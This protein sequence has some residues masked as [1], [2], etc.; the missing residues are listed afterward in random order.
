MS[1]LQ[2]LVMLIIQL[3]FFWLP[4]LILSGIWYRQRAFA[5]FRLHAEGMEHQLSNT[6]TKKIAATAE[7]IAIAGLGLLIL[8]PTATNEN[9][10]GLMLKLS[11]QS[12]SVGIYSIAAFVL[13][14]TG[15][16][17]S[18]WIALRGR[19]K[20]AIWFMSGCLV[21]YGVAQNGFP[22]PGGDIVHQLRSSQLAVT[23]I[24]PIIRFDL[25]NCNFSGVDLWV[26][27]VHLGKTPVEIPMS[28]YFRSVPDWSEFAVDHFQ[29]MER[30]GAIAESDQE[31]YYRGEYV[32][33][34]IPSLERL[35]QMGSSSVKY[36][37]IPE[38]E[39]QLQKREKQA[40]ESEK[41]ASH[42][43]FI[44][45][46]YD[47]QPGTSDSLT[48]GWGGHR[49]LL[50]PSLRFRFPHREAEI[51]HLLDRARLT[52]YE[53]DADWIEAME[54]FGHDGW[55]AVRKAMA[56]EPEM[57]MVFDTWAAEKYQINVMRSSLGA[58]EKL[59]EIMQEADKQQFYITA[60]PAGR[61][62]E[63]LIPRIHF[64]ELLGMADDFL[65]K[66]GSVHWGQAN[67]L[68]GQPVYW[69]QE[70]ATRFRLPSP[71]R[72]SGYGLNWNRGEK[73][74]PS[75]L[76]L[77][78]ALWLANQQMQKR[79]SAEDPWNPIYDEIAP[80]LIRLSHLS[81]SSLL[82]MIIPLGGA[83]LEK[84][85]LR[86]MNRSKAF[87]VDFY[88][89][90]Q[91]VYTHDFNRW[92][93]WGAHLSGDLGTSVRKRIDDDLR[94]LLN[95]SMQHMSIGSELERHF[96]FLF[97][98]K[99]WDRRSLGFRY[100]PEFRS[101]VRN[102]NEHMAL[103]VQLSYLL[104]MEPA[105]PVEVYADVFAEEKRANSDK[106]YL[107]FYESYRQLNRLPEEKR[108]AVM[109]AI[110]DAILAEEE[111]VVA[112]LVDEE[113]KVFRRRESESQQLL[114]WK[115]FRYQG[116]DD[117]K[118][119]DYY[120]DLFRDESANQHQVEQIKQRFKQ[121]LLRDAGRWPVVVAALA[122]AAE[123]EYRLLALEAIETCPSAKYRELL[124][125]LRTD[126]R[127]SIQEALARITMHWKVISNQAN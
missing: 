21:M 10:N 69:I 56:H 37:I 62:V 123:E 81:D 30:E 119:A 22:F 32:R 42:A 108:A 87:P 6:P 1:F 118:T 48:C 34:E 19:G 98:D 17:A 111:A 117:T 47:G 91:G 110:Y 29:K 85:L 70:E 9:S 12:R 80:K 86:Q 104:A 73:C 27:D 4:V 60:S 82:R 88:E 36:K 94:T 72:S 2:T 50:E 100:W 38:V 54:G 33:F 15:Y 45:V 107:Y 127:P 103:Q 35:R 115:E 31:S 40:T 120:L 41:G 78:Q 74:P 67:D 71:A 112:V 59:R 16:G 14:L 76:V 102:K 49:E 65:D 66:V 84:F 11:E 79:L 105:P 18:L 121:R 39:K 109:D 43:A 77:G 75:G 26:N 113:N 57:N 116:I 125:E 122:A 89:Q 8:L 44:R 52:D 68:F 53:I 83:P 25:I 23:S 5:G 124:Q 63:L 7:T 13:A 95:K 64:V 101:V 24:D 3:G 96:S 61:A 58:I 93:Y 99:Y 90:L 28:E 20:M 46:E 55:L 106:K 92:W 126:E 97:L 114:E 51:K